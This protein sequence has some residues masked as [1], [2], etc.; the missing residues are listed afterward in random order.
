MPCPQPPVLAVLAGVLASVL[1]SACGGASANPS[2]GASSNEQN[3][4]QFARCMREHGIEATA[5]TGP[6]SGGLKITGRAGKGTPQQME[7]AQKA[8]ARYRPNGGKGPNLTPAERAQ[9]ADQVLAFARCMRA[10]GI[11]VPNP[12]TS[13][14][15]IGIRI[16]GGVNPND[17]KFQQAQQACQKLLPQLKRAGPGNVTSGGPGPGGA[18]LSQTGG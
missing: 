12:E 15:H 14:G 9:R 17:P 13:G 5:V 11:D 3:I 8:C 7:A 1:L 4:A 18:S 2:A 10:H 6:D 16:Q